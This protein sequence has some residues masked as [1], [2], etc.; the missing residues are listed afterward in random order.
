MAISLVSLY[1]QV[2][3]L[4]IVSTLGV[5]VAAGMRLMPIVSQIISGIQQIRFYSHNMQLLCD[6]INEINKFDHSF[7]VSKINKE[8]IYFSNITLDKIYFFYPNSSLSALENIN[9]KITRG[10]AIGFIGT[11]GAGKSTLITL[12]LGFITPSSGN[13]FVDGKKISDQRSWLNNFAYI[14]QAIF[15]LDDTLKS[16][17][18]MGVDNNKIDEKKLYYAIK[19]AQ[20]ETF[21]NELPL[22]IDTVLGENGARISGGQKQRIAL[23]RAFYHDRDILI[24]DEA[25]S[26][27]DTGT[28]KE[29]IKEIMQL[30]NEKTLIFIAH[31]F[32]TLEYCDVIYRLEKGN[33]VSSGSYAELIDKAEEIRNESMAQAI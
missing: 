31:R 19:K 14:P 9:L 20:L 13:I 4:L 5:F 24:M 3:T 25:T 16:N 28:E 30:K 12:I 10:Q 7:C 23:A 11:S 18:A 26:A 8:K 27:L 21:V 22:G 2:D 1:L 15:L 6:S 17:I 32:S 33:I 29:V